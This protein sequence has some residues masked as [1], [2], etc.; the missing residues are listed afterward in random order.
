MQSRA[1]A[2]FARSRAQ[3]WE[4][5]ER[6]SGKG[7]GKGKGKPL[8]GLEDNNDEQIARLRAW[9]LQQL[10]EY[11]S[12]L[13]PDQVLPS[14]SEFSD[15]YRQGVSDGQQQAFLRL[16]EQYHCILRACADTTRLRAWIDEC[17]LRA[18]AGIDEESD[19]DRG[20]TGR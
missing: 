3:R 6:E 15:G 4:A 18:N 10:D 19:G 11:T 2:V 5:Y 14:G 8:E 20:D 1:A 13:G 12:G 7:K 17:I 16:M 9:I